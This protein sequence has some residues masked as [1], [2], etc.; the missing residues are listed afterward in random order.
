MTDFAE[1]LVKDYED[2]TGTK[3]RTFPTPAPPGKSLMKAAEGSEPLELE[4]YR[5]FVG[6]IMWYM[7][8]ITPQCCNA[9][10]ELAS[11]M[12]CPIEEHWRALNRAIGY[13][14][15]NTD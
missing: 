13:I 4:R 6:R 2:F 1:Q 12:Q 7:R 9:M 8:R 11:H 3:V 5:S 14:K 15:N 10:R